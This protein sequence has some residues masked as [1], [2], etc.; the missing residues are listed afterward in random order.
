[1]RQG[2][3]L[4]R[5]ALVACRQN[6]ADRLADVVEG[7]LDRLALAHAAG[8]VEAL[9]D[10]ATVELILRDF[11]LKDHLARHFVLATGRKVVHWLGRVEPSEGLIR[12]PEMLEP[13]LVGRRVHHFIQEAL[14]IGPREGDVLAIFGDSDLDGHAGSLVGPR[15]ETQQARRS[16][17]VAHKP[18]ESKATKEAAK[19]SQ[20]HC[21]I[22]VQT[23]LSGIPGF[24]KRWANTPPARFERATCH[25]DMA[26]LS[27]LSYGG[28]A[29]TLLAS[30]K[31][32]LRGSGSLALEASRR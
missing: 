25:C 23:R 12:A 26:A 31:R 10:K 11:D 1:M 30:E 24:V 29:A 18:L 28:V 9:H 5:A 2:R 16:E 20:E 6:A 19:L 4:G 3:E 17:P 27:M 15:P 8:E 22:A 13:A 14:S 7:L 21:H 32:N